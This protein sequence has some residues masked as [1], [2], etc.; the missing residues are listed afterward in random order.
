MLVKPYELYPEKVKFL[1]VVAGTGGGGCGGR[2]AGASRAASCPCTVPRAVR[3][4]VSESV[5]R[6]LFGL[7]W[8]LMLCGARALSTLMSTYV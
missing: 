6:D 4:T 5:M 8:G 7:W 1:P 2:R 3:F